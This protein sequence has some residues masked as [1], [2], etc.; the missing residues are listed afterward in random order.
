LWRQGEFGSGV[1]LDARNVQAIYLAGVDSPFTCPGDTY[2]RM[3]QGGFFVA[4]NVLKL[5]QQVD[6]VV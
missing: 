3:R 1:G 5:S 2:G 4:D 6:F